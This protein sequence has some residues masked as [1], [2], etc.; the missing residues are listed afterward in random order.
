MLVL[1]TGCGFCFSQGIA[2]DTTTADGTR[3]ISTEFYSL[4][5]GGN[6]PI[7][8]NLGYIIA[9]PNIE[10]WFFEVR[11]S[12]LH[13]ISPKSKLLFKTESDEILELNSVGG[14]SST[15][16]KYTITAFG[17]K[18]YYIKP[19]YSISANQIKGLCTSRIVRIRI[20]TDDG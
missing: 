19:Y 15:D 4:D 2:I 18:E 3:V 14:V 13:T 10:L 5:T 20:E 1:I 6:T 16:Y 12:E 9:H 11:L 8:F 17:S 7:K